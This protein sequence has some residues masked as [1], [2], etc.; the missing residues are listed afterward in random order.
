MLRNADD[1]AQF[2]QVI[3]YETDQAVELNR[4]KLASEPMMQNYLQAWRTLFP[5]AMKSTRTKTS[6][7]ID[8]VV[9]S[10]ERDQAIRRT[11]GR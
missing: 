11:I 6:R 3:E 9:L 8:S 1:Q 5:G 10:R 7:T 4:Q 2:V